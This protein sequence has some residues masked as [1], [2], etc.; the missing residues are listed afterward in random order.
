LVV[1]GAAVAGC[2][3][4]TVR[5]GRTVASPNA[6]L[7]TRTVDPA[8][9][10]LIEALGEEDRERGI[11]LPRTVPSTLPEAIGNC[12]EDRCSVEP[13]AAY[14]PS[15]AFVLFSVH[16]EESGHFTATLLRDDGTTITELL[17]F[18]A[19]GEPLAQL[20][21]R[22]RGYAHLAVLPD[23]TTARSYSEFSLDIYAEL[24]A[25][26][27]PLDGWLLW[28]ETTDL[29][30][31][32][33]RMHLLRQDGSET[34]VVAAREA[35]VGPCTGGGP[36]CEVNDTDPDA[37][38]TD[39]MLEAEGRLC[40]LPMSVGYVAVAPNGLIVIIGAVHPAGHADLQT[41]HWVAR[42]P[43]ANGASVPR[44]TS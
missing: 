16:G 4:S 7:T 2:T 22:L 28:V 43:T 42:L 14:D 40:V 30:A 32:E 36:W 34:H 19:F 39:A 35:T 21:D 27:G 3:P 26:S 11:S 1:L 8:L 41:T 29:S 18:D 24:V 10:E 31:R 38:C 15:G 9:A 37:E 12:R 17:S 13:V 5:S 23:L 6:E 20:R 44:A 25:L 33:Y